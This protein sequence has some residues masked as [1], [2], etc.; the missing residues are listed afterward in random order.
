[1]HLTTKTIAKRKRDCDDSCA[2]CCRELSPE[3]R[4]FIDEG[5]RLFCSVR[6]ATAAKAKGGRS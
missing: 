1:V 5:G 4:V 6:C 3:D 2:H